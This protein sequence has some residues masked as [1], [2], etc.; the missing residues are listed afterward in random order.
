M[1]R[2]NLLTGL[3]VCCGFGLMQSASQAGQP[4]RT[5][6]ELDRI[7]KPTVA[8]CGS[9][10]ARAT[11]SSRI[12]SARIDPAMVIPARNKKSIAQARVAKTLNG[13]WNGK[14]IGDAGDVHVDYFWI[15]DTRA[16]EGLIIAQRSGKQSVTQAPERANAPK[17][18]YL[19]CAHEGYTPGSNTPQIHEFTKVSSS[20]ANAAQIVQRA[21]GVRFAKGTSLSNMWRR[22]VSSGYFNNLPYVAYAGG[23]FKPITI[24]SVRGDDGTPQ[25]AVNWNGEYRGGGST[26]L[27][28]TT[29]VPMRGTERAQFVGTTARAGDFLVSSLGNGKLWQVEVVAGG[30]YDLSF[31]TVSIGPLEP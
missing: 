19:M 26:K 24:Q 12:E 30:D 11:A 5:L 13:V 25:V 17:L 4:P 16:N 21:T 6:A 20:T 29:G 27:K 8:S 18:T 31:D 7:V 2:H 22:L 3:V 14:V 28:Y 9:E 10:T 15:M 23:F 1:K